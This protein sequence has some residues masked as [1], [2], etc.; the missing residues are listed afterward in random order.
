MKE[1]GHEYTSIDGNYVQYKTIPWLGTFAKCYYPLEG[2]SVERI[3]ELLPSTVTIE[4]ISDQTWTGFDNRANQ[5]VWV[6]LRKNDNDLLSSFNR[7]VRYY[8]RKGA[9]KG[10]KV[11]V[12]SSREA[13]EDFWRIFTHTAGRGE[14]K[15]RFRSIVER[16]F[17]ETDFSRLFLCYYDSK[18]VAAF[19]TIHS[20]EAACFYYGGAYKE[21]LST[22]ASYVGHWEIIRYYNDLG[23]TLYDMA[24][25]GYSKSY[26]FKKGWGDV[27]TH[28]RSNRIKSRYKYALLKL[29]RN[30]RLLQT[31]YYGVLK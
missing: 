1:F 25:V 20:D 4:C 24:G 28:Y 21:F 15:P 11:E 13:F 18:P 8:I 3:S 31:L 14:F 26:S 2:F 17:R 23:K 19:M 12:E 29:F 30:S 16:I 9:N 5:T 7:S 27:V 22:H 10:V 6:W